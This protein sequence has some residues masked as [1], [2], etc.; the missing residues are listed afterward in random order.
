MVIDEGSVGEI[1][2][3]GYPKPFVMASLNNDDLNHVTTYYYLL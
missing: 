1:E 2:K 3:S